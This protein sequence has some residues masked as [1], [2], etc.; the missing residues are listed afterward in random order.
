MNRIQGYVWYEGNTT[1]G[2]DDL[3]YKYREK[4]FVNPTNFSHEVM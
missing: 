3:E 4:R 2:S 1:G